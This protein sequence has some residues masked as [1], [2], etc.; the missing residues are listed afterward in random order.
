[1][2][3]SEDQICFDR[4]PVTHILG[5]ESFGRFEQQDVDLFVGQT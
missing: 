2:K 4:L 1:M 3:T 5:V